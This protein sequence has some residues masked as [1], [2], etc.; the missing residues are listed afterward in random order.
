MFRMKN[1][2][3]SKMEI[4]YVNKNKKRITNKSQL[5]RIKKLRI[6]PA[7]NQVIVSTQ[8]N[9]KVQAIGIDE[10][11]RSQFIYSTKH[12]EKSK[13]EKYKRVAAL[14]IK[15][16]DFI[17]KLKKEI[18]KNGYYKEKLIALIILIIIYTSLRIGNE[19]NKKLYNSFG[20]TTLLKKHVQ[21]PAN[22]THEIQF[23]FIGK[24][25]VENKAVVK[26]K[27]ITSVMKQWHKKFNPNANDPFFQ[28]V[29][30]NGDT[31]TINAVDVNKY[32]NTMGNFTAKDFRTY[33]ANV[34][35]VKELYEMPLPHKKVDLSDSKA[36][37]IVVSALKEVAHKLNNTPA[38]CRKEYCSKA[39][40]DK[41]MEDPYAFKKII[42][43]IGT[44]TST[45]NKIGTSFDKMV[46]ILLK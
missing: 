43:K 1:K 4:Y 21:F 33:N 31:Y 15:L 25:G 18:R 35:L 45:N 41:Y 10:K 8:L 40:I 23:K 22:K 3:K 27:L 14:G 39:I 42:N 17:K 28:Y 29:G 19:I 2:N 7:W 44:S 37:K 16:H 34:Q 46:I 11:G 32:I 38:V 20:L 13:S 30:Y 9:A 5:E 36:K 24:K 26:D 12:K 6:P